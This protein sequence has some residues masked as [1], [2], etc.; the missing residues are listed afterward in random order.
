MVMMMEFAAGIFFRGKNFLNFYLAAA[1]YVW[2]IKWLFS[3]IKSFCTLQIKAEEN[4]CCQI[5]LKFL[6]LLLP[7]F[8]HAYVRVGRYLVLW[9]P[10]NKTFVCCSFLKFE[11]Q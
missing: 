7:S 3:T 4:S 2:V 5:E 8:L 1:L 9:N 10:V 6:F 11:T